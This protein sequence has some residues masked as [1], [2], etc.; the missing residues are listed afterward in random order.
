MKE[1]Y[2]QYVSGYSADRIEATIK[3]KS[4]NK[5][6]KHIYTFGYDAAYNRR[7]ASEKCPYIGD[8][9]LDLVETNYI[10]N[11]DIYYGVYYL[12]SN[13]T[14]DEA[15]TQKLFNELLAEV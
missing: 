6:E 14:A 5:S 13:K 12:F 9:L 7:N 4:T 11:E 10:Y 15:E 1:L 8:I 2:I 3:D